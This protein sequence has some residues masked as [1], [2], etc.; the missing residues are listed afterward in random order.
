MSIVTWLSWIA[1]A[2]A[3]IA[4]LVAIAFIIRGLNLRQRAHKEYY[5]V[6]KQTQRR[7]MV[8]E[9]AK[10]GGFILLSLL[11]WAAFGT[12]RNGFPV[13][14]PSNTATPTSTIT[15]STPTVTATVMPMPTLAGTPTSSPIP[16]TPPEIPTRTPL[17]TA[18]ITPTPKPPTGIVNSPNGLYLRPQPGSDQIVELIPD[19]TEVI[20]LPER[21]LFNDLEWQKVTTPAGNQGWVA[22]DFIIYPA[23]P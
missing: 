22:I 3:I 20:L 15:L 13:I 21:V 9:W 18:T 17:P 23:E 2:F 19:Q 7:T 1:L 12:V 5:T 16:T 10:G 4:F 8:T 14:E 6:G 11:L